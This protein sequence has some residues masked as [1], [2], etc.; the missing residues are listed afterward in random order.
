MIM[1]MDKWVQSVLTSRRRLAIPLMTHPGI[2]LT[3]RSV[4]DAVTSSQHHYEAVKALAEKYPTAASTM[5]MDLSIEAEAFGAQI[6]FD[7]HEVP[8]VAARMVTNRDEIDRLE[9]PSISHGRLRQRIAATEQAAQYITDRPVFAVCIGPFSLAARL[10]DVS[11]TMMATLLEPESIMRLTGT[12]TQFLI[13]YCQH[14]K[15]AGANAVIIAEPVAGMVSRDLCTQFSSSFIAEIVCAVQDSHFKVILHNCGETDTLLLSM[16]GTGAAALHFGAK[17]NLPQALAQLPEDLLIM[18]N[19]DPVG[20][21]R[22]GQP[23]YV[24]NETRWLLE[25]TAAHKNFILSSGCDVP[26]STP[27]EN[28]DAFFGALDDFNRQQTAKSS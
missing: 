2:A 27:P 8:S 26:P 3:G 22:M 11:E 18:G 14:L 15:S 25:E 1:D 6:R 4:L 12:C 21:L 7:E 17:C 20:V 5:I 10:F 19:L 16:Q 23:D 24:R 13:T 9:V 28:I